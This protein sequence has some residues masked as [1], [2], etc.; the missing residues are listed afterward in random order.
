MPREHGY[1]SAADDSSDKGESFDGRLF[2]HQTYRDV[3]RVT[4]LRHKG[5]YSSTRGSW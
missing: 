2:K 3:L 1:V 5:V 4:T